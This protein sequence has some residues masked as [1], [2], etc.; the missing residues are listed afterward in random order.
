MTTPA[1]E[2][3]PRPGE[4]HRLRATALVVA[5]A[6]L[7]GAVLVISAT[8][9]RHPAGASTLTPAPASESSQ[10]PISPASAPAALTSGPSPTSD[11]A[12]ATTSASAQLVTVSLNSPQPLVAQLPVVETASVVNTGPALTGIGVQVAIGKKRS[13]VGSTG[14]ENTVLER[15]NAPTASWAHV[16]LSPDP[17]GSGIMHGSF[18]SDI[19]SSTS[20]LS[21]RITIGPGFLPQQSG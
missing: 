11:D 13:G 4:H 17:N 3:V 16:T 19:P 9:L 1:N 15:W 14:F 10:P 20:N 21:L 12:G 2:Q 7:V 5:S 18:P 6:S 8:V